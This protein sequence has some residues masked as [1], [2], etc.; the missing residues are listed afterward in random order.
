VSGQPD[1]LVPFAVDGAPS[2]DGRWTWSDLSCVPGA[3]KK[4]PSPGYRCVTDI[5][6]PGEGCRR[7]VARIVVPFGDTRH[8]VFVTWLEGGQAGVTSKPRGQSY[9]FTEGYWVGHFPLVRDGQRAPAGLWFETTCLLHG[10]VEITVASLFDAVDQHRGR[11]VGSIA[12]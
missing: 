1:W 12:H 9:E 8:P 3:A 4:R 10:V 7:T 2:A 6:C 11:L 5:A